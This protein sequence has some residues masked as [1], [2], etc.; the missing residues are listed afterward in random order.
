M[1]ERLKVY[2]DPRQTPDHIKWQMKMDHLGGRGIMRNMADDWCRV[3]DLTNR[4]RMIFTREFSCVLQGWAA[5]DMTRD[6]RPSSV[7]I[8]VPNHFRRQ[9]IG[10]SIIRKIERY[11]NTTID[12][13]EYHDGTATSNGFYTKAKE[14][15][16]A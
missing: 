11:F 6:R 1:R 3:H 15:A 8:Y 4:D 14:G 10:T 9:G 7:N 2:A 5:V 13:L 12:E 16:K